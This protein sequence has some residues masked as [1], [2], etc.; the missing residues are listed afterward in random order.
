M[1]AILIVNIVSRGTGA[2]TQSFITLD[3]EL[4]EA[5]LDKKG[6]RNIEDIKKVTTFGY[7]PLIKSAFETNTA[8]AGIQ[9]PLKAK[10]KAALLSKSAVGQIREFVL[11]NPDRIGD[12]VAFEFLANSRVDGYLKGRVTPRQHRQ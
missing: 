9:S 7:S 8:I 10:A 11:A 6:N 2:F 3:V 5:K 1:V 12:T 4:L